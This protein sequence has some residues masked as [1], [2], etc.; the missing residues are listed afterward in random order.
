MIINK[1]KLNILFCVILLCHFHNDINAQ[2]VNSYLLEVDA[3]DKKKNFFSKYGLLEDIKS[4]SLANILRVKKLLKN[5][6]ADSYLE[7]QLEE[8]F[9]EGE[10][11]KAE[12]VVGPSYNW[13]QLEADNIDPAFLEGLIIRPSSLAEKTFRYPEVANMMDKMVSNAENKGYPFASVKLDSV[14]ITDQTIKAD[15][16]F[17]KG[18]QFSL[19]EIVLEGD[20]KISKEYLYRF[21]DLEENEL[22]KKDKI[23]L[24][25]NKL[26]ELS[27]VRI[28]KDPIIF[29]K[30]DEFDII[31]DLSNKNASRFDFLIGILPGDGLSRSATLT[32]DIKADVINQLGFGERFFVSYQRLKP[33]AQSLNM[34]A[35][36][37]YI[38]NLPFGLEGSFK[39]FRNDSTFTEIIGD[40]GL[41]YYFSGN[42]YLKVFWNN[43]S[44][45]VHTINAQ[46]IISQKALSGNLDTR[47]NQFGVLYKKRQLDYRFNPRKGWESTVIISAG[48]KSVKQNNLVL[49][50]SEQDPSFDYSSLYDSLNLDPLQLRAELEVKKYFP[51]FNRSTFLLAAK[52]AKLYSKTQIFDNELFRIGGNR[53]LRGFDEE[54]INTSTYGIMTAEYRLLIGQ[55]SYIAIFGDYGL[56]QKTV[57][58]KLQTDWPLG[59]GA[60][61]SFETGAGIFAI[62]SAFGKLNS[63]PIDFRASKIHLGYLSIF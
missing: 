4:D 34:A 47:Y 15:L 60:G 27:F 29:F 32:G 63:N 48:T 14:S 11:M 43:T 54:S 21:L 18:P 40:F 56:I 1:Y 30:S 25:K 9:I 19:G 24:F 59:I 53:F 33:Q 2:E 3:K 10:T 35:D 52:G 17:K 13:V 28:N 7:S 61:L 20:A 16:L 37:P 12:I 5:L 23:L 38:L 8:I 58:G 57:E 22:F 45:N 31:L 49:Q 51:L 41:K 55:N 39:L 44:G 62:S 26:R 6:R 50:L 36:Y 42:D 46:R